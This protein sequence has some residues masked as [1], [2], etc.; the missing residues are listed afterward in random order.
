MTGR[1]EAALLAVTDG[2]LAWIQADGS[3]WIN[4][5]GAITTPEARAPG[6]GASERISS[7]FG[8]P[9]RGHSCA[10]CW[11]TE[12]ASTAGEIEPRTGGYERSQSPYA[13]N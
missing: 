9:G 10:K 1:Q 2:V 11:P 7:G 8:S 3:W 6:I 4:N 13:R 5:A 12:M